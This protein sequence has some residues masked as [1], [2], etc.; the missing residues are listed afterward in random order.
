MLRAISS[1]AFAAC[2]AIS[3]GGI[4][5]ETVGDL[6]GSAPIPAGCRVVDSLR[7]P[8][9]DPIRT[10]GR[11]AGG[12]IDDAVTRGQRAAHPGRPRHAD[13]RHHATVLDP[14]AARL[15]AAR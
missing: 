6:R 15:A 14:G 3:T 9:P 13:E 10:D 5:Q 7:R 4:R 1:A 12:R 11:W 8:G 2:R